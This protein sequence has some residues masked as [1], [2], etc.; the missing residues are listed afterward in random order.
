VDRFTN[1]LI[2]RLRTPLA[3]MPPWPAHPLDGRQPGSPSHPLN[4]MVDVRLKHI[5][6]PTRRRRM[7]F[8]WSWGDSVLR[9]SSY[10]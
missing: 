7:R 9:W 4:H 6:S 1:L 8:M 10:P 2:T 3:L 5:W